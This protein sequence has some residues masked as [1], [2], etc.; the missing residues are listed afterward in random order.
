MV[1]RRSPSA[2]S[3]AM[4]STRGATK[5]SSRPRPAIT[6]GRGLTANGVRAN[7]C[8]RRSINR[9]SGWAWIMW[10][11]FIRIAS[12][13][14]RRWKK[15]WAPSRT[16]SANRQGAL[17]RHLELS[18]RRDRARGEDSARA[19]HA[20]PHPSGAL[21][22]AR[23]LGGTGV[24]R[25]ARKRRHRL[26]GF[27][28]LAKGLLTNRY[29]KGIPADSRARKT[30]GFSGPNTTSR[31]KCWRRRAKLNDLAQSRGQ[32]LAQMAL[33]W[34]LRHKVVTSA[35]IGASKVRRW[36]IAWRG[37]ESKINQHRRHLAASAPQNR[38]SACGPA[39]VQALNHQPLPR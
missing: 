32:T 37:E 22:H 3:C 15:R 8:W 12:T 26:H 14:R 7:I 29:F 25:H 5:S 11:F 24:V 38:A 17:R 21:F 9:S 6:C 30:R 18:C 19:G 2:K 4:I 16:R 39:V 1:R 33:A 36:T 34:V 13:P 28:P 31:T 20:V 10:I 23:P 35:L 27:S